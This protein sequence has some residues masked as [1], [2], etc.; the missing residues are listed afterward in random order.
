MLLIRSLFCFWMLRHTRQGSPYT[1]RTSYNTAGRLSTWISLSCAW[2]ATALDACMCH[3]RRWSA[4]IRPARSRTFACNRGYG[5]CVWWRQH[6]QVLPASAE[7]IS[8]FVYLYFSC[9]YFLFVSCFIWLTPHGIDSKTANRKSLSFRSYS[10]LGVLS[11]T[12][13]ENTIDK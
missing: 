5:S 10:D 13:V 6:S 4:Q 7:S 8:I 2:C 9:R 11:Y 3:V 1:Q 12:S